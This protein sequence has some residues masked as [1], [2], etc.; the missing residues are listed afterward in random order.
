MFDTRQLMRHYVPSFVGVA[1]VE[2]YALP[3]YFD[4]RETPLPDICFVQK[5]SAEQVS[6]KEKEKG[7]WAALSKDEKIACRSCVKV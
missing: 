6:L 1:K 3:G 2:D 7:S 4:K 5:L